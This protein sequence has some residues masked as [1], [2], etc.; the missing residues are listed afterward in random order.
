MAEKIDAGPDMKRGDLL[1]V[2][3]FQIEVKNDLRGRFKI[4]EP[5]KVYG[6]AESLWEHGQQEPVKCRKDPAT[7]RLILVSGFTRNAAARMIREGYEGEDEHGKKV[8]KHN[9]AFLLSCTTVVCNDEGALV[10]NIVENAHRDMTS[11]VDDAHNQ[12]RLREQYKYT[13]ARIARLYY[14]DITPAAAANRVGR[15]KKILA[16]ENEYQDALHDGRLS[17]EG[18]LALLEIEDATER[19]A[20]FDAS[21][22]GKGKVSGAEIKNIVRQQAHVLHDD[23][24]N[25]GSGGK[26]SPGKNGS[27][28]SGG[29]NAPAAAEEEE[30]G[31]TTY[32]LTLKLIKTYWEQ[33]ASADTEEVDP[34]IKSFAKSVLAFYAGKKS[35]QAM[36][37]AVNRLL[38][39]KRS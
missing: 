5:H 25:N 33:W 27:G 3:P 7:K 1:N 29:K 11:V 9:P 17:L 37:N 10:L 2:D 6:M 8:R 18:G 21:T 30:E 13:D 34:A 14:K 36:D 28:K 39:A 16:L 38:D 23:H 22:N 15:L 4:P 19:K 31:P 20:A 26:N 12:N 35:D 24:K 32:P